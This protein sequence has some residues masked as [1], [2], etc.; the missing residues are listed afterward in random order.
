MQL[1]S[2]FLALITEADTFDEF[3]WL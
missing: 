1:M 2:K 3:V